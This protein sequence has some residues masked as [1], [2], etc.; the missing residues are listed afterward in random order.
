[1]AYD[2]PTICFSFV[3]VVSVPLAPHSLNSTD[4]FSGPWMGHIPFGFKN[5]KEVVLPAW[6]YLSLKLILL[7]SWQPPFLD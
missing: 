6:N 7:L 1:M 4:I 5:F 3:H 2:T